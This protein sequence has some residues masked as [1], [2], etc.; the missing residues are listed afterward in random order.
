MGTMRRIVLWLSLAALFAAST[1]SAA[2]GPVARFTWTP[3]QPGTDQVVHFNGT[4]SSCSSTPCTYAWQ[5]DGPDGP[6]GT[7]FPLGTG[8]TLDFTF[9]G[10]GTKHVRLTVKDHRSRT[11]TVEHDVVVSQ[12]APPSPCAQ[13]PF[14]GDFETGDLSQ[15]SLTPR[16][17]VSSWTAITSPVAQGTFAGRF[18]T[19]PSTVTSR[20]EAALNPDVGGALPGQDWYYGWWTQF[21]SVNGG[22]QSW[23]N[24]GGDWNVFAQFN[25]V[26]GS[27]WIGMG[28]DDTRT[29]TPYTNIF[30]GTFTGNHHIIQLQYDQWVHFVLHIRWATDAT[31]FV[32][33]WKDG[34]S[35]WSEANPTLPADNPQG[36]LSI[37]YYT[38]AWSA[39]NTVIH[40][41]F[42]RASTYASAAAC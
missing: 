33:L 6:G 38:G 22:P 40:D 39:M 13:Q 28:I 37:G 17:G 3:A 12:A 18:T 23:W 11:S 1:A 10:A 34:T 9:Q 15:W 14:C 2:T 32:E 21:P 8:A 42:C 19:G 26:D 16:Q 36:R 25:E 4:T 24:V 5:D 27:R 29:H 20:F 41:G 7:N 31:G 35:V 30:L